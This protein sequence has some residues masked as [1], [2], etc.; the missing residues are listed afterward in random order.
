MKNKR[1]QLDKQH[2]EQ[3]IK[4]F[5][6]RQPPAIELEYKDSEFRVNEPNYRTLTQKRETELK[7][8]RKKMGLSDLP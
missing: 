6:S 1:L 4:E 3:K 5:E 7:W 8:H 2:I